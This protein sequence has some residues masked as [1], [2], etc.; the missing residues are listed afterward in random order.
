[1]ESKLSPGRAEGGG[2]RDAL[3]GNV[4]SCCILEL[5]GLRMAQGNIYRKLRL[6]GNIVF[7]EKHR[8]FL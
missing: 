2:G 1:M 7:R 5:V 6:R 4:A 8:G 3:G